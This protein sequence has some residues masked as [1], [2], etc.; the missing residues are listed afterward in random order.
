MIQARKNSRGKSPGTALLS[1]NQNRV[2]FSCV[3]LY[4]S[5]KTETGLAG[6]HK[7]N[8]ESWFA[9]TLA[10]INLAKSTLGCGKS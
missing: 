6:D 4:I 9:G 1:V 3:L 10:L 8:F 5:D 2:I 7:A